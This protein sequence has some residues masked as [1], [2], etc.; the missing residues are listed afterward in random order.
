MAEAGML[1]SSNVCTDLEIV[2]PFTDRFGFLEVPIFLE[3]GGY[4]WRQHS[5]AMN[6]QLKNTVLGPGT[7]I[8]II[9]PMHFKYSPL[10]LYE[11]YKTVKKP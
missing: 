6:Q 10:R 2:L 9:H 4:L 7:K 8:L 1:I 11:K 3:D 5:L